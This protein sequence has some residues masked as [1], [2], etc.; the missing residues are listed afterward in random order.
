MRKL[1][2]ILRRANVNASA[3]T[4]VAKLATFG[5]EETIEKHFEHEQDQ[6]DADLERKV[7]AGREV[8]GPFQTVPA[9]KF[10]VL[11]FEIPKMPT[12]AVQFVATLRCFGAELA[13]GDRRSL[14]DG[15][16]SAFE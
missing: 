11:D 8:G 2:P 5:Q 3:A 15:C 13:H 1:P 4:H 14:S 16:E 6:E 9:L 10:I 12:Q 7:T